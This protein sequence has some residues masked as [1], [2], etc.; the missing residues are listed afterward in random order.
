MCT[1]TMCVCP[2]YSYSPLPKAWTMLYLNDFYQ[3][4]GHSQHYIP[5]YWC[6]PLPKTWTVLYLTD[7]YQYNGRL[8]HYSPLYSCSPSPKALSVRAVLYRCDPIT[9]D[10]QWEQAA[11]IM[12][13]T[14][15]KESA[16]V[17]ALSEQAAQSTPRFTISASVHMKPNNK[18][19]HG[20]Q[21]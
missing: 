15:N 4:N 2:F 11:W 21:K 17:G 12:L 5:P 19:L 18:L 20:P 6:W 1:T 14:Q 3:Y 8:S 7:V 10:L 16:Q 13:P 9:K